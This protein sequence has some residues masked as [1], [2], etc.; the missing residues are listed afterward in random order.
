MARLA[1]GGVSQRCMRLRSRKATLEE[2]QSVHTVAYTLLFGTSS[3]N[4]P[5][6][7]A[8]RFTELPMKNFVRLPCGGLGVDSD[9]T[10]NDIHTPYAARMAAGCVIDLAMKGTFDELVF[11]V[12]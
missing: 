4:N 6:M 10:W 2:I 1:E 12:A 5:K 9:T 3:I 7:D 8:S 11:P